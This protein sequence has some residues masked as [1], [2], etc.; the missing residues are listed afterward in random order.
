M[1]TACCKQVTKVLRRS[2]YTVN[3]FALPSEV[4]QSKNRQFLQQHD[5]SCAFDTISNWPH[6]IHGC[7]CSSSR[8]GESRTLLVAQ[9]LGHFH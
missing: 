4:Q 1:M 6:P 7:P 9:V 5:L 3:S 8:N 2:T